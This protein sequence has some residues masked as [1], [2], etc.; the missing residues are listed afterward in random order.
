MSLV[1]ALPCAYSLDPQN[2]KGFILQPSQY[3]KTKTRKLLIELVITN[4][5]AWPLCDN[6]AYVMVCIEVNRRVWIVYF[7]NSMQVT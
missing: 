7:G 1:K 4:I 6:N 2:L 5:V 3:I